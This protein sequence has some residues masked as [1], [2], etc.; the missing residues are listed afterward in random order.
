MLTNNF[1]F[2]CR[3]SFNTFNSIRVK[4]A[5]VSSL[6]QKPLPRKKLLF[7]TNLQIVFAITLMA[8]LGVSSITPAFP[9]IEKSM[10]V[11]ANQVG[12]LITVF[13]I[14]GVV[15]TP[16]LGVLADRYGRKQ[17]L[18]PSLV[19]FGIAGTACFF[20]TTFHLLLLLRFFQGV[21]AASLGSLNV[22]LIGDLYSGRQRATAMGYNASA[23][24]IGT[25]SYPAIGGAMALLGWYVPFLLPIL[26]IPVGLIVI[27]WLKN[28]EPENKAGFKE[29]LENTWK[30]IRNPQVILLFLVCL[31]TFI[32]LYGSVLTYFPFF[33][34]KNFSANSFE[35]GVLLSA[36]SVSTA[37]VSSQMGR[38]SLWF[39]ERKLIIIAFVLY[40]LSLTLIPFMH[41]LWLQLIP[42]MIF[43]VAQG[44]NLPS[45]LN[46]LT[47]FAPLEH[48]GVFMSINGMVIR[49]GQTIGPLFMGFLLYW[50]GIVFVF[51]TGAVLAGFILLLVV[52]F[53]KS[54]EHEDQKN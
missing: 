36:M 5:I 47:E 43:G 54:K 38:L 44:L 24:S 45:F 53:L 4:F 40:G 27:F 28:P 32:I 3:I 39:S 52:I 22:T 20:V 19:L 50:Q 37:I 34:D 10:S 35:I 13:T 51:F 1:R 42:V 46:L 16:V 17:I 11:T 2:T 7:Q 6:T 23:L 18:V 31:V 21:G 49:S 14:P 33:A 30:S 48:R 26:A 12:Y 8:V 41:S 15:L 29:Y 25:A 9:L